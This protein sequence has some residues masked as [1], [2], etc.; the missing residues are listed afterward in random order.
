MFVAYVYDHA[1]A[2][3]KEEDSSSSDENVTDG[4]VEHVVDDTTEHSIRL[5]DLNYENHLLL[6]TT[7][8]EDIF[9]KIIFIISVA[10]T[11]MDMQTFEVG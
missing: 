11:G 8:I 1:V 10:K 4:D 5:V 2:Y 9:S 6:Y 3:A 7:Y